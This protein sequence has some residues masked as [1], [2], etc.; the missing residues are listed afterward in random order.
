[1]PSIFQT[2][3]NNVNQ[4]IFNRKINRASI[5]CAI[6][7]LGA[8]NVLRWHICHL[9]SQLAPLPTKLKNTQKGVFKIFAWLV[10]A[11]AQ[12]YSC[13]NCAMLVLAYKIWCLQCTSVAYLPPCLATRPIADKIKK[14]PKGCF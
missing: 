1:M 13:L 5:W 2:S 14:H 4:K 8:C 9:A 10:Q 12:F 7:I 11:G 6:I 3:Q